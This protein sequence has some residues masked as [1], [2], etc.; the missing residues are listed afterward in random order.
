MDWEKIKKSLRDGA[1]MSIEKIE[2]YTKVGKLK[3]D[4]MAAKRKIE[5]N[6]ADIGERVF[7]LLEEGNAAGIEDDLTV[8]NAVENVK[9]LRT[10]VA[11]VNEKIAAVQEE[12][13][14]S[15]EESA[16]EEPTGV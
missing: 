13:R 6:F 2:E 8:K 1:T 12:A 4:E 10:E 15:R 11:S 14:K 3:V 9:S 7:D 16:E 5:R